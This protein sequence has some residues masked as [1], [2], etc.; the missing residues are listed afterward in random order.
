MAF[1]EY[2]K[3]E[4][5]ALND[6]YDDAVITE[7][8]GLT[9]AELEFVRRG[10]QASPFLHKDYKQILK[11]DYHNIS[12]L[13]ID[14]AVELYVIRKDNTQ[15]LGCAAD[16]AQRVSAFLKHFKI[17]APQKKFRL[18]IYLTDWKKSLEPQP[19]T[20]KNINSG[21]TGTLNDIRYIVIWR[22]EEICKVLVHELIHCFGLDYYRTADI[23]K[24]EAIT[25][26][27][28][29]IYHII[30]TL[31]ESDEPF[32]KFIHYFKLNL[33][34]GIDMCAVLQDVD[35]GK[36]NIK[37][38]FIDR[39][40]L[41]IDVDKLTKFWNNKSKTIEVS[42]AKLMK[43]IARTDGKLK[44]NMTLRMYYTNND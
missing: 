35:W 31:I 36:A 33:Q 41:L 19:L 15:T 42:D 39:V 5:E 9:V 11:R 22:C 38:Y 25:E 8:D 32:E 37:G 16:I 29:E 3:H 12:K 43:T 28:A 40:A 23:V 24:S 34:Y 1:L 7:P 30:F 26:A 10:T 27:L 14:D 2:W 44:K 17:Q 20:V 18:I 4:Y 13:V 21:S 6:V